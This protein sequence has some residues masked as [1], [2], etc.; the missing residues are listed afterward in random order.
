MVTI[1][2][3]STGSSQ[4]RDKSR[5]S[6][7]RCSGN[8]SLNSRSQK[9]LVRRSCRRGVPGCGT[10]STGGRLRLRSKLGA[11]SRRGSRPAG[12]SPEPP[13][14]EARRSPSCARRR[15]Q[16]SGGTGWLGFGISCPWGISF[17]WMI[18]DRFTQPRCKQKKAATEVAAEGPWITRLV[19]TRVN[20]KRELQEVPGRGAGPGSYRSVGP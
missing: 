7:H 1:S 13:M 11:P 18:V 3:S 4:C 12:P 19:R 2:P 20:R 15:P 5:G 8:R 9:R 6:D 10:E 16:R 14:R 17:G